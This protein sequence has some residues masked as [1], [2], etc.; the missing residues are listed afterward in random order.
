MFFALD[1]KSL[2]GIFKVFLVL[3]VWVLPHMCLCTCIPGAHGG[4]RRDPIPGPGVIH[5]CDPLHEY[6]DSYQGP[7]EQQPVLFT[8]ESSLMPRAFLLMEMFVMFKRD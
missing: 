8:T 7:L 4:Q 2:F 1:G 3:C 6:W 5:V